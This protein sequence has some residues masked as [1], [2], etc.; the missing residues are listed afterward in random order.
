MNNSDFL[1]YPCLQIISGQETH[2]VV[3]CMGL[4]LKSIHLKMDSMSGAYTSHKT[5]LKYLILIDLKTSRYKQMLD[6]FE[7]WV[8]LIG[9]YNIRTSIQTRSE[10][11]LDKYLIKRWSEWGRHIWDIWVEHLLNVK[12]S[13]KGFQIWY[14]N[15]SVILELLSDIV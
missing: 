1:S 8:L 6:C 11:Y 13:I 2:D 15:I 4:I 7:S 3:F 5:R 14:K 9:A 12:S 10:Y